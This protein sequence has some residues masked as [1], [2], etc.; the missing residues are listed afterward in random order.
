M[1]KFRTSLRPIQSISKIALN[2]PILTVGSCFADAMGSRF[3]KF[4]FDAQANPFGVLF[5]PV[6]IHKALDHALSN[7]PI[8]E[9]S[10]FQN[11]DIFY[12]YDFH[13]GFSALDAATL[14][15]TIN[16]TISAT[17]EYLKKTKW[18]IITYGT[19][20]VYTLK[21][22]KTVVANCHKMPSTIFVKSLLTEKMVT[23]S[24]AALHARL[25]TITPDINIVLTVSPVRHIKD[26]LELNAVSKAL[27]RLACHSLSEEYANVQ[28]FPAYEIMVDD[29]RDYRFYNPDM[30]HPTSVAEEYIWD[31]FLTCFVD[32][33]TQL[34]IEEWHHILKELNHKPFHPESP[35]HQKFIRKLL[36]R[37]DGI[38]T[39]VNV[40]NELQQLRA[41]LIN[42]R[43]S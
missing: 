13:S 35:D 19:A 9:K 10:V 5:N 7:Q 33:P 18:L 4:K 42:S 17:H 25:L 27:L 29:L 24:F 8:T 37:M 6:S 41:Q 32:E 28:Y 23:E 20:L 38:A 31:H 1:N 36:E 14:T 3:K 26:T 30:I 11:R 16:N 40:A 21:E 39:K 34:F 2:Q 12:H 43:N 22:S 15:T